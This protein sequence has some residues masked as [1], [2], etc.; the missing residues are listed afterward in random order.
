Q[1]NEMTGTPMVDPST[2]QKVGASDITEVVLEQIETFDPK[3]IKG[4]KETREQALVIYNAF[5]PR[6]EA[7]EKEK[8][9]KLAHMKRGD[10]L[11]SGVLEMVKVYIATKRPL[12][13]GDK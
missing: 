11:P 6:I 4:S 5:W 3:W 10:E 1:V 9:R 13:V 7:I 2:R 12:S 8:Q